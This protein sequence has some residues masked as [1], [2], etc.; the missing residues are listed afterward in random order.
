MGG[1]PVGAGTAPTVTTLTLSPRSKATVF[2]IILW[3]CWARSEH[4]IARLRTHDPQLGV[5]LPAEPV[6][7]PR[8]FTDLMLPQLKKA[9][10][11]D[12]P[13]P[14][15]SNDVAATMALNSVRISGWWR[16]RYPLT[17]ELPIR[18]ER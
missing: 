16:S 10:A 5:F 14:L 4:Y 8:R 11:S 7:A 1:S 9:G 13:E 18:L 6:G 12:P 3:R 17:R 15:S 2:R